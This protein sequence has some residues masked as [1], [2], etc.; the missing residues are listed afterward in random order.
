MKIVAIGG[1]SSYTPELIFGI[2]GGLGLFLYGMQLLS[3]G[4]QKV[5]GDRIQK[6]MEFLN[7]IRN[8]FALQ[9][10][11]SWISALLTFFRL[12]WLSSYVTFIYYHISREISSSRKCRL[13]PASGRAGLRPPEGMRPK[14]TAP[15]LASLAKSACR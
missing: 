9:T 7:F 2:I 8:L 5:T 12:T 1:G 15:R 10:D 13:T 14:F 11:Q 6:V 3:D 4:L